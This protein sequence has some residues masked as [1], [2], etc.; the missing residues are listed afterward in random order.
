MAQK[1]ILFTQFNNIVNGEARTS[2]HLTSGVDPSTGSLL[3]EVPVA[4]EED[5]NDAVTAAQKAFQEWSWTS[6]KKRQG[7]LTELRETLLQHREEMV[8]LV[9]KET[10]KPVSPCT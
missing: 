7:L 2:T 1:N 5:L 3:W 6:G 10:G 9:M 4:S 8:E